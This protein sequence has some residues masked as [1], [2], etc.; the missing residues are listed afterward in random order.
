MYR[1][2]VHLT[3]VETQSVE[4]KGTGEKKKKLFNT[5]SVRKIATKEEVRNHLATI[6][7]NH[8]I[9]KWEQGKKKGEP[10]VY[11]ANDYA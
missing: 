3:N 6:K 10:M 9:A 2:T 5:I 8:T 1:L 11:I 7:S 4:I